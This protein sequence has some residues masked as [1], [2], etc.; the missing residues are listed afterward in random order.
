MDLKAAAMR[1]ERIDVDTQACLEHA[2]T[3]TAALL[4]TDVLT[5]SQRI[6]AGQVTGQLSRQVNEVRATDTIR[7]HFNGDYAERRPS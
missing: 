2:L 3:S 5:T 7:R 4:S 6:N 1:L